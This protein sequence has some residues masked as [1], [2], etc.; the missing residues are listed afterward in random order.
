MT[1]D[2]KDL[3]VDYGDE[4][5]LEGISL[6]VEKGELVGLVGPNGAGKTTL[7]RTLLGAIEPS[8]G[9]ARIAGDPVHS[10]SSREASQRLAAVPQSTRLNFSFTVRE[11]VEMGRHPQRPRVGAD[12]NKDLIDAALERTDVASLADRAID[13]VSGGERQR[14]LIA[15]ALA[16]DTPALAVDEP[17][18]SLDINHQIRTLGLIEQLAAEGRAILAAIHDLTL[19]ARFCDRLILLEGGA[20]VADGPPAT[21]LQSD[22]LSEIFDT[23]TAVTH[24]PVTDSPVVTAIDDQGSVKQGH[25]HVIGTGSTGAHVVSELAREGYSL[26]VGVV[27]TNGRV[28]EVA[29]TLGCR[30]VDAPPFGTEAP[31][32]RQAA[33]SLIRDAD[34]TVIVGND[35]VCQGPNAGLSTNAQRLILVDDATA[36]VE[37]EMQGRPR[38]ESQTD[39]VSEAVQAILTE[40]VRTAARSPGT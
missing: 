31:E 23:Q 20:V 21:V 13:E 22:L 30:V 12:T 27:P 10:L 25:V 19:A 5:V 28:S 37:Q 39:E 11:V 40:P 6:S 38:R 15:R 8:E 2:V 35:G 36:T 18:A 7:I 16:Q 32:A 9:T 24:D 1:L 3:V 17:T 34:A 33:A 29:E 14:V 26:S 4:P